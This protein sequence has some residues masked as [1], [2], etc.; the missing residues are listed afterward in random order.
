[1]EMSSVM[2]KGEA[3]SCA[4]GLFA[5]GEKYFFGNGEEKN[6][7]LAKICYMKAAKC[8]DASAAYMAGFIMVSGAEGKTNVRK[9][10]AYLK[11]AAA[12]NH[13]GALLFLARNYYYGYG[14]KRNVKKAYLYW[15]RGS[16][17]GFAE[18]A[19]YLGLCF[20]KGIYVK[21]NPLKARKYLAEALENGFT[22]AK[23]AIDDIGYMCK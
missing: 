7:P 10:T 19:Y 22:P 21:Q 23:T 11:K 12:K 20:A 14:V 16:K 5:A 3:I 18:A 13:D 6:V 17:I 9:G 1:M 8:G 4:E 15:E 2:I